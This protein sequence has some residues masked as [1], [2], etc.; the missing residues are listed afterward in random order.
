MR[1]TWR[2]KKRGK[3]VHVGAHVFMWGKTSNNIFHECTRPCIGY[4]PTNSILRGPLSTTSPDRPCLSG[5]RCLSSVPRLRAE[6]KV[7]YFNPCICT[8]NRTNVLCQTKL[9]FAGFRAP[10]RAHGAQLAKERQ[11]GVGGRHQRGENFVLPGVIHQLQ[12]LKKR[13]NMS[14]S[15][16][17]L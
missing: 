15:L 16:Y 17:V 12:H 11:S 5:R 3:H 13:E 1:C 2:E 9:T 6:K 4:S 10:G 14:M 7:K 8:L